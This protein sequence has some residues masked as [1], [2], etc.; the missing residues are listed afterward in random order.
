M[1]KDHYQILNISP[2]ASAED[3]KKS[4]RKL[5]LKY[6][7][8]KNQGNSRVS[9]VQFEAIKEAYDILI[10][11][12]KRQQYNYQF[13]AQ[14]NRSGFVNPLFS[15]DEVLY[16]AIDLQNKLAISDPFRIDVHAVHYQVIFLLS[17]HNIGLLKTGGS[18][19]SM[20]IFIAAVLQC[21]RHLPY[22]SIKDICAQLLLI[23][24]N[25]SA[26][27]VSI[28][29]FLKEQQWVYY[30]SKYKILIALLIAVIVCCCI[31]FLG[32]RA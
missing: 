22:S 9:T 6:H 2:T 23:D 12:V 7:P 17:E 8:D 29:R 10:D 11:P 27:A 4:F 15:A 26:D 30:W 14:L 32:K 16:K 5:A 24:D 31:Y 13:Y 20:R 3:V 25:S 28:N 18:G 1:L 21:S 19:E